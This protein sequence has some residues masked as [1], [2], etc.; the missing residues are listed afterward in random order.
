[1]GGFL[2]YIPCRILVFML[3]SF[4]KTFE[5]RNVPDYSTNKGM[6]SMPLLVHP[7]SGRDVRACP[8]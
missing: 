6:L 7:P 3:G 5:V 8:H 4:S 1:M 2:G